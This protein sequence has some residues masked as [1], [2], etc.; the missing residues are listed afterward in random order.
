MLIQFIG[1]YVFKEI[2]KRHFT[3][4][5][6]QKTSTSDFSM[7]YAE[8]NALRYSAGYVTRSVKKE[9]AKSSHPLKDDIVWCIDDMTGCVGHNKHRMG[10]RGVPHID[11]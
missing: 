9:I 2:V 5:L 3:V 10:R 7:S 8:K 4:S 6:S 11:K 1:H